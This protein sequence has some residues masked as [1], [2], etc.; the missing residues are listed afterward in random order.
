M[1]STYSPQTCKCMCA[2]QN[3]KKT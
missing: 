2:S 1:I 3:N